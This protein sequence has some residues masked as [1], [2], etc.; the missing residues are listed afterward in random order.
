[1]YRG[2]DDQRE[3]GHWRRGTGSWRRGARGR[4]RPRSFRQYDSTIQR[5]ALTREEQDRRAQREQRF[6]SEGSGSTV[7]ARDWSSRIGRDIA[8]AVNA[9]KE[10]VEKRPLREAI[11]F[12]RAVGLSRVPDAAL[13]KSRSTMEGRLED[14]LRRT[15]QLEGEGLALMG[16]G[17]GGPVSMSKSEVVQA[18]DSI[19]S[20]FRQL[21]MAIT[22]TSLKDVKTLTLNIYE[23]AADASL[24][25]GNMSFYLACQSRLVSDIYTDYAAA[26]PATA[27]RDEFVGYSLLYFGVFSVDNLELATIMKRITPKMYKSQYVNFGMAAVTATIHRDATKFFSLFKTGSIRQKTLMSS[28]IDPMKAIALKTIIRSYLALEKSVAISRL[29]LES[30]ADFLRLLKAER[31]DLIPNNATEAAEFKFRRK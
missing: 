28:S 21:T 17:E 26:S 12:G 18:W 10:A 29:G 31:P 3:E 7:S 22:A 6:T 5:P 19:L 23:G 13:S 15:R 4:G 8:Q 14:L 16:I 9:E 24:L 27:R 25:G 20:G 2:G 30:H 1:M 11:G